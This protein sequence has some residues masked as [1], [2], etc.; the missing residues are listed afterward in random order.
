VRESFRKGGGV[1]NRM[2]AGELI[3]PEGVQPQRN[4]SILRAAEATCPNGF[5]QAEWD[6]AK[7]AAPCYADRGV[8]FIQSY[9]SLDRTSAICEYNSPDAE[10]IRQTRYKFGIPCDRVWSSMVIA[11]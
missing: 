2:W 9:V 4:P 1:F 10:V 3:K 5:T 8:E 11:P 6:Q 7:R